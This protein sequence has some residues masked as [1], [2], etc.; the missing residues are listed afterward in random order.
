LISFFMRVVQIIGRGIAFLFLCIFSVI[1]LIVYLL[2]PPAI[3]IGFL[4]HVF[5]FYVA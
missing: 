1:F 2:L 4:Y 3:L 5:G